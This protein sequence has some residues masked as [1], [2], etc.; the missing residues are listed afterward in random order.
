MKMSGAKG[1]ADPKP[2]YATALKTAPASGGSGGAAA[3][4]AGKLA[5]YSPYVESWGNADLA[6]LPGKSVTLAFVIAS[7]TDQKTPMFDGRFPV[8]Q[9]RAKA[10][11]SKKQVVV[12]F[13]GAS[14]TELAS[15]IKDPKALADVYAKVAK[16]YA[17]PRLDF[18][19]EGST[20]ADTP[21]VTRR[22]AALKLL[23]GML[24]GVALQYTLPV[25][26]TGLDANCLAM[27]KDA[28]KQGVKLHAVNV[29]A[30]DYGESFTGDMGDYAIQAANA[31]RRQL[32]QLGM[33]DVGVGITPMILVND[34]KSEV[35]TIKNAKAVAEFAAKTPWVK[36]FG[37]WAVG[38]DPGNQFGQLFASKLP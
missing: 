17:C 9:W 18:D 19:I 14:G 3:R 5:V 29:M 10:Q 27:L 16:M 34:I 33:A 2:T 24:P 32:G 12:S 15:V 38:R 21:V 36:F 8:D 25:M 35:F 28:K 7:S 30:M 26:P 37:Y 31:T 4:P 1:A 13:G 20:V 23:Q 6:K 22:N 11:A